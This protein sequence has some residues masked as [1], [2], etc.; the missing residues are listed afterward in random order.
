MKALCKK[1]GG[2]S[3][4][5]GLSPLRKSQVTG[6][7]QP[8]LHYAADDKHN[9]GEVPEQDVFKIHDSLPQMAIQAA[10]AIVVCMNFTKHEYI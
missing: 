4:L 9:T 3:Q 6:S 7:G 5:M 1:L 2:L 8:H 10:E